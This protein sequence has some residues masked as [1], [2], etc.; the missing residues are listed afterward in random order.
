PQE[1][2]LV[3]VLSYSAALARWD[4]VR[5]GPSL[6]IDAALPAAWALEHPAAQRQDEG[7]PAA[8]HQ[9]EV[10]PA[11]GNPAA[12]RHHLQRIIVRKM[13]LQDGKIA[14]EAVA[15]R[16]VDLVGTDD[17][18]EAQVEQA[19]DEARQEALHQL[20]LTTSGEVAEAAWASLRQHYP[21]AD[22]HL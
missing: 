7:P 15:E 5:L 4:A 12:R 9:D 13:A 18:I 10:V 19:T 1:P 16:E 6:P 3:P 14:A 21:D 20:A 8:Q 11:P 17:E 2:R 22:L